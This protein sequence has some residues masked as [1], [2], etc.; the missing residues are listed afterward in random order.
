MPSTAN[1][2]F[3]FTSTFARNLRKFIE[4]KRARGCVYDARILRRLRSFDRFVARHSSGAKR[5]R[6]KRVIEKWLCHA[7]GRKPETVRGDLSTIRQFCLF[8]RRYDARCFVPDLEMGPKWKHIPRFKPYIYTADEIRLLL[9]HAD[10]LAPAYRALTFRTLIS[11]LYCTGI[12]PGEAARLQF[13][14][15][16]LG[17]KALLIRQ[18]KGKTRW[19]PFHGQLAK[20]IRRHVSERKRIGPTS[21]TSLLFTHP[22][23]RSFGQNT[24]TNTVREL[25]RGCGLK[26]PQGREG[27]RLYDLRHTYATHVLLRWHKEGRDLHAMLPFLSAYM[28]HVNLLGTEVYLSGTPELLQLASRRFEKRFQTREY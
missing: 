24:I 22:N 17:G 8:L 10:E 21:P 23:G 20:C 9:A 28:G 6:L 12:R 11:V 27:P 3:R 5:P 15:L 1:I 18:S 25:L 16:D 19:V 2:D 14:D 26:S 13:R 4:F 7:E